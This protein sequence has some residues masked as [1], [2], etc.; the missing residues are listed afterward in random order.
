[1]HC[2][3]LGGAFP[4][5]CTKACCT[6]SDCAANFL[7]VPVG[8]TGSYC[9]PGSVGTG[10]SAP[11]T[12]CSDTSCSTS[13]GVCHFG[14]GG[15]TG[16][17]SFGCSGAGGAGV[18]ETSCASAADCRDGYCGRPYPAGSTTASFCRTRC[19]TSTQCG[20]T[21]AGFYCHDESSLTATGGTTDGQDYVSVCYDKHETSQFLALD[22][23]GTACGGD[24][25]CKSGLCDSNVLTG[26]VPR[27]VDTCCVDGDCASGQSCLSR[28]TGV[29]F[30]RCVPTP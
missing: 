18:Q 20:T 23:N 27:C 24:G 17:S 15:A 10:G 13:G 19:C 3:E 2:A 4:A 22:N 25:D 1:V 7:C 11:E 12:C 21:D 9:L 8:T 26:G 6:S 14:S 29:P 5:Q 30:L 16:T 28:A